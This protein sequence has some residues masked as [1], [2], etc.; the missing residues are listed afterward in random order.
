MDSDESFKPV[1][2][3]FSPKRTAKASDSLSHE[4]VRRQELFPLPPVSFEAVRPLY[5]DNVRALRV[6]S[7][8][9]G[10]QSGNTHRCPVEVVIESIDYETHTLNGRL[11]ICNLQP[12]P[13]SET[14]TFFHGEI[15]CEKNPFL[16]RKWESE[17]DI[18]F[19]H[20]S[21]FSKHFEKFESTFND[22]DF[23]YDAL[24]SNHEA[25]FMRWKELFV[26]PKNDSD[27]NK[28]AEQCSFSGFYYICMEKSSGDIEGFYFQK[29]PQEKGFQN[30]KLQFKPQDFCSVYQI[31]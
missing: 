26:I 29:N 25:I 18:D 11:T 17:Y 1:K 23:D 10:E 5:F 8:F 7:K 20:W 16:T 3:K 2:T 30:L 9:K 27:S 19:E 12:E 22:D 21:K 31:R 4:E 15:I 14:T 13:N 6:G 24:L 28:E